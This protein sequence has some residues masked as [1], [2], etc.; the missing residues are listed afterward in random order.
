MDR[1]SDIEDRLKEAEARLS[2]L[3][4]QLKKLYYEVAL[5]IEAEL[6]YI[7]CRQNSEEQKYK[8][9][10]VDYGLSLLSEK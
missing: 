2:E 8:K 1:L 5:M 3:Q 6:D 10:L 4:R 7:S 9:R